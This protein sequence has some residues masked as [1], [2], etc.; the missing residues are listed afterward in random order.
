VLREEVD[1]R[2]YRVETEG[3]VGKVDGV[4]IWQREERG[5]EV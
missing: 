3:V 2:G 4:E 5:E 1:E